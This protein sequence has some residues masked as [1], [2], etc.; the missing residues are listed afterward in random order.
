MIRFPSRARRCDYDRRSD[1]DEGA[2]EAAMWM[3]RR[4]LVVLA[5][6]VLALVV[7]AGD[8]ASA[9]GPAK[10]APP[11]SAPKGQPQN[12]ILWSAHGGSLG[13]VLAD[14]V[15]RFNAQQSAVKLT[16][17]FQGDYYMALQKFQAALAARKVPDLVMLDCMY[18]PFFGGTG[19]YH[20]LD[21]FVFGPDGVDP[22]DLVAGF[23]EGDKWDGRF[24]AWSFARSTP[25]LYVNSDAFTEAGLDPAA[26]ATWTQAVAAGRKTV[27]KDGKGVIVRHGI[28]LPLRNWWFIESMFR[29]NGGRIFDPKAGKATLDEPEQI[30]VLQALA[31]LAKE[32][33]LTT[34]PDSPRGDADF[35]QGK[36][37]IKYGTTAQLATT[38]SQ[39]KFKVAVGFLPKWKEYAVTPGGAC[40]AIPA[41]AQNKPAAW[42]FMKWVTS[43]DV[44]AEYATRTGYIPL[45]KSAL[46]TPRLRAFYAKNPLWKIAID[47]AQ[48]AAPLPLIKAVPLVVEDFYKLQ[49]EIL[50]GG[51]PV[52]PTARKYSQQMTAEF[53]DWLKDM[54]K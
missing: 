49:E 13:E 4:G 47:Q 51:A 35:L 30:A 50:I 40:L 18:T 17:E 24:Y 6:T 34:S 5:V 23:R 25:L 21:E 1:A 44:T 39:A 33:V 7:G 11:V 16:S 53:Q 43:P 52:T 20:A 38:L 42:K 48:F 46:E 10:P 22:A 8:T 31:D 41:L 9:A 32:Q 29:S 19:A 36:A 28:Q 37:A 27:K 45:R 54:K 15:S 26:P 2:K 12:A 3:K 14:L